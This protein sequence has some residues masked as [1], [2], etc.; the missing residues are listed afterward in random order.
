VALHLALERVSDVGWWQYTLAFVPARY[1][2]GAVTFASDP[3]GA[4]IWSFLTHQLVHADWTH[5][6]MNCAWL[7]AFGG[8][9]AARVGM[10]RFA[11]LGLA[12]GVA[13]A[14]LFLVFRWGEVTPMAGASGAVSGLMG[15]A[16]RFF[17]S[18]IDLGGPHQF[19]DQPGLVP[20]MSL[21]ETLT[22]R[23]IQFTIGA[24]LLINA[25][26]AFG[27]QYITSAGGIAWEAH[28][29]G[30]FFGLLAFA[31]FDPPPP[32]LVRFDPDEELQP[33]TMH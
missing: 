12:S 13:G 6:L 31:L 3:S 33:P 26:A 1:A 8:A 10:T 30:F 7:L 14:L 20:R 18:A 5:L 16:F 4:A 32:R 22:D 28:L 23:R 29:G 11:V 27:A 9:V 17:F 21:I 15:A 25:L 19:R 2:P 24:F